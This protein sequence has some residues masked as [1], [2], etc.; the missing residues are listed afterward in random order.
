MGTLKG[1]GL[2]SLGPSMGLALRAALA[3]GAKRRPAVLSNRRVLTKA[4]R[5]VKY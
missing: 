3:C 4:A 2:D 1:G 5:F